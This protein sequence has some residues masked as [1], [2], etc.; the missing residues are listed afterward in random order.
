[1]LTR[2]GPILFALDVP[3]AASAL[4]WVERLRGAVGGFK[5]GLEL[6]MAAGPGVVRDVTAQNAGPLLLDLKLHDI[7]NTVAGAARSLRGL[8]ARALTVHAQGGKAML[9]AAIEGAGPELKVLAVTRLTSVS[10]STAEVVDAAGLAREAGC[11][12]VVCSGLEAR[13]VRAVLGPEA[14]IVVPGVRIEGSEVGDQ[15]R[16]A[17]PAEALSAGASALV[18]GRPIRNAKDPVATA[19]LITDQCRK[20]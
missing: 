17:T 13:A 16:V 8:G 12:G 2:D 3:D 6:F 1:M 11:A 20:A 4:G 14:W 18:V 19:R 15:V 10:A 9:E 7:P 5:V